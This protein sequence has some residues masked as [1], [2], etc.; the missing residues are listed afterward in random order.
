MLEMSI[1]RW[2]TASY[3]LFLSIYTSGL[4]VASYAVHPVVTD[5]SGKIVAYRFRIQAARQE[6]VLWSGDSEVEGGQ[7][8]ETLVA[9]KRHGFVSQMTLIFINSAVRTSYFTNFHFFLSLCLILCYDMLLFLTVY[10]SSLF[11][12][13]IFFPTFLSFFRNK[14]SGLRI[15]LLQEWYNE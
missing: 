11:S 3:T 7:L 13:A 2:G 9:T 8:F 4:W 10:I 6:W 5:T 15:S 12:C 14:E 1:A